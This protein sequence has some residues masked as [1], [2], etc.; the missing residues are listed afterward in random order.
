M[1]LRNRYEIYEL[2]YKYA[3]S[4]KEGHK[5]LIRQANRIGKATWWHYR[6]WKFYRSC[7]KHILRKPIRTYLDM[8]RK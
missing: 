2:A 1:R 4:T 3:V 7:H 8:V 6:L 5:E